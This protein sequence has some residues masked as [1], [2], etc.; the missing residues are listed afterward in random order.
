LD[1]TVVAWLMNWR[2]ETFYG[3][4]RVREVA[5]PARMRE[6]A[7]RPGRIWVVTEAERVA[8]LEG[9][10]AGVKRMRVAGPIPG[11]YRLLELSDPPAEGGGATP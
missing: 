8:S 5:D 11:R 9:A 10:V 6:I 7:S 2:G 3:R 1:E 4:N